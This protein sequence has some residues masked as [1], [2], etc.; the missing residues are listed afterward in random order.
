MKTNILKYT[1]AIAGILSFSSCAKDFL[2]QKNTYQISQDNFFDLGG[3]SLLSLRVVT[4][5]ERLTGRRVDPRQLFFQNLRLA[6]QPEPDGT[7]RLDV[8]VAEAKAREF[9]VMDTDA[10]GRII[11]FLEKPENP[12]CMPGRPD[13]SLAS[14]GIYVC[15]A[16][17]LY[18]SLVR[19]S[20]D[21]DSTHDFGRD[22]I[23]RFVKTAK[24]L[25][26]IPN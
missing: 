17:F 11:S 23:P 19:D 8:T 10:N 16:E 6:P 18:D 7:L 2:E 21:D 14:M 3:H 25:C 5:I 9:G 26:I 12:P 15:T 13:V 24:C 1:L 4:A 20:L 22:F